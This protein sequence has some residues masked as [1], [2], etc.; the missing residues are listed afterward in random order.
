[1]SNQP[2]KK[3]IRRAWPVIFA[4]NV[5][6][7]SVIVGFFFPQWLPFLQKDVQGAVV[8]PASIA[9]VD[10]QTTTT[11][12]VVEAGKPIR[13]VIP[14]VKIDIQVAD[15][16]YNQKTG[17]WTLSKDKAHYATITP[18]AN[19][20]EGNTFIYGHNRRSVFAP[21]LNI[22]P[23]EQAFIYTDNNKMFT[24]TLRDSKDVEPTDASLFAYQ[25]KPILTLQT[26][27]GTWYQN[28]SL[29]TFEFVSVENQP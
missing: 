24:Y 5:V 13:L 18:F 9:P 4:L 26:C 6:A 10:G 12:T 3:K 1:M 11:G 2:S 29:F 27:S 21:L 23:G 22:K 15:G 25:G 19:N 8:I 16:L 7:L 28:R 20:I 14:S 17:E